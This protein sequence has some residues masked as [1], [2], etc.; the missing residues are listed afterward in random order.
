MFQRTRELI[1]YA[2]ARDLGWLKHMI[3]LMEKTKCQQPDGWKGA[4]D[5]DLKP[6]PPDFE[7]NQDSDSS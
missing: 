7:F 4:Y 3:D 1:G 2:A 6:T 5:W